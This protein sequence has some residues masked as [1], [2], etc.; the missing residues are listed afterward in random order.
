MS[1]KRDRLGE[2]IHLLGDLLGETIVEQEGQAVFELVEEIRGLAK[3][4]RSGDPAAG[5]RLLA[6]VEELPLARARPVVKAFAA[7][8][9]L[10]NLA[11]EEERVRVLRERARAAGEAGEPMDETIAAAIHRLREEGLDAAQVQALLDGLFIMPVLTAHPTEAKRRTVLTKLNLIAE[12]LHELDFHMPVPAETQAAIDL[13]REGILSLWQ[14]D[15]TRTRQ[16]DVL[17]EVRNGLYYFD[18]TLFDLVPQVYADL[19]RALEQAYPGHRF[20]VPVF[21]RFGSWIGGDR[22]GNP[23]VTLA[24]TEETLREQ[25]GLALRLYQ[26]AIDRMHGHLSV[27]AHHGISA[28]LAASLQADADLFP[29]AAQRAAARYPLQPYRHKMDFVYRKLAA[30]IEANQRPWR[31]DHLPRPGTYEQAEDFIADLR[32]M[33]ASLREHQAERL[34]GGRLAELVRQAEIFGFHLATLD[35]RQHAERHTEAL[36]EVFARYRV[37]EGYKSEAGYEVAEGYPSWPEERKLELLARE[38]LNPRPLAPARLD[39]SPPTNETLELFRLVRRAHERVGRASIESYIISMTSGASDVLGVLLMAKDAG[40]ADAL[41]IVPL[42]ETIADLQ[43][44]PAIMAR[45][46]AN[47]QYAQHLARRGRAQQ[48]MIG[49]SDSNKDG[50]YLTANWELHLVQRT[51][52]AICE[53][54]GVTLTLFHGRGGTIG[55]GGGPTNRA[56]LAQP[57]ESVR[58]RLKLTEQGEAITNR[59]A[60]HDLAHRHLE[61]VVHAVLLT[62][63]KRPVI[64]ARRAAVWD[65]AMRAL[66]RTAGQAYRAMVHDL[67]AML[68]Y[69][70]NATPIDDIGR[71]NIGSRPARRHDT[72][73]ID[74]LRAIP[75]G[76]AWSQSRVGLPGWF[77]LGTALASWAG[78]DPAQWAALGAMYREWPFFRTTIDNAQISLRQADMLIAGVYSTLADCETCEAIFPVLRGEFERTEEAIL[79][80]TGQRDLLDNEPWLQRSIRV[81]NPYIDPMNYIQVALLCRLRARCRADDDPDALHDAVLLTVNGIAAGLRGTG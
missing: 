2:Q 77:G 33:Q 38:L 29:E 12:T 43:R 80:L 42:F 73:R 57:P 25:K 32:L 13:L 70:H 16:P 66:A 52:P 76:F 30:T 5:Q 45:L 65:Q 7:Y 44:A 62:S 79:R 61:Q 15:E 3:A 56:I 34:A 28:E 11:E 9:Q 35:I 19:S 69:F 39:F 20:D 63:G 6:L 48:I 17:D 74:D 50:G 68:D 55:R 37:D 40:V 31:A 49:Y 46:F 75:W 64:D 1:E 78:S 41:D 18:N 36:A 10:V 67:P 22:D 71:L 24:V 81:R 54:H 59:Y 4:H 72:E 14:T 27:S 8:F 51:L 60:N 21:L 58:G 26:R 23:N 53:Q 47:R